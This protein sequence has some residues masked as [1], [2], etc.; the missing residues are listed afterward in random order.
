MIKE[1]VICVNLGKKCRKALIGG[2]L[3]A[4]VAA[5]LWTA[6]AAEITDKATSQPIMTKSVWTNPEIKESIEGV[7]SPYFTGETPIKHKKN[8]G[9]KIKDIPYVIVDLD[10]AAGI[11]QAQDSIA[12]YQVMQLAFAISP[13]HMKA[14]LQTGMT[15]EMLHETY[16]ANDGEGRQ[17]LLSAVIDDIVVAYK[18]LYEDKMVTS[19][20]KTFNQEELTGEYYE[21]TTKMMWLYHAINETQ[22][23]EIAKPWV[24]YWL[25]GMTPYEAYDLSLRGVELYGDYVEE[26]K[27]GDSG[28]KKKKKAVKKEK[29][30]PMVTMF[31]KKLAGENAGTVSVNCHQGVNSSKQVAQLVQAVQA[32]GLDVWLVSS[33]NYE[34]VRATINYYH[35]PAPD[36]ILSLR[37]NVSKA[38][39]YVNQYNAK[40]HPMP[41]GYGKIDAVKM[42]ITDYYNS[43]QPAML[44][45]DEGDDIL[46]TVYPDSKLIVTFGDK[47]AISAVAGI[48][49]K[50]KK[51]QAKSAQVYDEQQA[52]EVSEVKDN[53]Q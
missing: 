8:K 33:A 37:T 18:K 34:T 45:V 36:G 22:G 38:G 4:A 42:E 31:S 28:K 26:P 5:P 50:A 32:S 27:P 2:L 52:D 16:G 3:L 14:V 46:K 12:L 40:Y 6:E 47:G 15:R 53:E 11:N 13:E 29:F 43:K 24:G 21:F 17:V 44:V 49:K 35:V 41:Y 10:Q 19:K 25:T 1:K 20:G 30:P 9:P 51:K 48:D 39:K 23:P 7:L